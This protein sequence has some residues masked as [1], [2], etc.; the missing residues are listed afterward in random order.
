MYLLIANS[1]KAMCNS[2]IAYSACL[3]AQ[4]EWHFDESHSHQLI[5]DYRSGIIRPG[6]HNIYF[7][8][9][10]GLFGNSKTNNNNNNVSSTVMLG[11]WAD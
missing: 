3:I 2:F 8:R 6:Y 7:C 5:R 4:F 11:H 1:L 10:V 9:R